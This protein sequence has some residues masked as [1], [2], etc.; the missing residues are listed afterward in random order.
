MNKNR[1]NK[2]QIKGAEKEGEELALTK[3]ANKQEIQEP[4]GFIG[5]G[6]IGYFRAGIST[7]AA[8]V[9]PSNM[10]PED[11]LGILPTSTDFTGL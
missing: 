3:W 11:E 2:S 8:W 6:P 7:A 1:I 4:W 10:E 5:P 9:E